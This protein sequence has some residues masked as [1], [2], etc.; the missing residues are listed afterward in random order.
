MPSLSLSSVCARGEN[1][2]SDVSFKDTNPV[3]SGPTLMTSFNLITSLEASLGQIHSHWESGFQ[4]MN[5]VRGEAQ[6]LKP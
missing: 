4:R 2:L 1:K 3:E 6:I 5:G